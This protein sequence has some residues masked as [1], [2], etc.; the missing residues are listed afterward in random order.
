[1][2][3]RTQSPFLAPEDYLPSRQFGRH[4]AGSGYRGDEADVALVDRVHVPGAEAQGLRHMG[5]ASFESGRPPSRAMESG[6]GRGHV[7]GSRPGPEAPR[8][9]TWFWATPALLLLCP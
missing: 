3:V 5:L 4:N 2:N 6:H 1:M 7:E 8:A 9:A